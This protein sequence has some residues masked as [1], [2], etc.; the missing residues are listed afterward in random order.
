MDCEYISCEQKESSAR[1]MKHMFKYLPA[2][3]EPCTHPQI[4]EYTNFRGSFRNRIEGMLAKRKRKSRS[5]NLQDFF[6]KRAIIKKAHQAHGFKVLNVLKALCKN[7]TM[8]KKGHCI[9]LTIGSC[10]EI[11]VVVF[12][13]DWVEIT[14]PPLEGANRGYFRKIF[15]EKLC[16][17]LS[18]RYPCEYGENAVSAIRSEF[19]EKFTAFLR[20]PVLQVIPSYRHACYGL[21]FEIARHQLKGHILFKK[22]REFPVVGIIWIAVFKQMPQKLQS[23]FGDHHLSVRQWAVTYCQQYPHLSDEEI[24]TAISLKK[25]GLRAK[26][27]CAIICR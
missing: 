23:F 10:D 13:N 3:L 6:Y 2:N 27:A 9:I 24:L 4:R 15:D 22:M 20:K 5:L 12:D 19:P 8:V 18:N 1:I 11:A 7:A 17:K 26:A 14:T 16:K 25:I 21:L